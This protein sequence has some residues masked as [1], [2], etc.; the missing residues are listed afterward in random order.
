VPKDKKKA[1][2]ERPEKT[3]CGEKGRLKVVREKREEQEMIKK[4]NLN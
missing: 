3:T 1:I 4:I 2:N